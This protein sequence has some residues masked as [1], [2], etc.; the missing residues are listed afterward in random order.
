[1]A[2]AEMIPIG[3]RARP[4][5]LALLLAMAALS[6][7]TFACVTPFVAFAVLVVAT[8][9]RRGAILAMLGVW[10]I[11]QALGYLAL[12]YPVN[13][14]GLAWGVAIGI[15]AA[16]A[17]LAAGAILARPSWP[18]LGGAFLAAVA[19]YEGVLFLV[20]LALGGSAN[21]A[22]RIIALVTLSDAA[23]LI[24]VAALGLLLSR[25]AAILAPARRPV[26]T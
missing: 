17:T 19:S 1:M 13:G 6:S 20:S 22:P 18:R 7:V 12:G 21:F 11:N 15:A 16:V 14:I 4:V 24:G 3:G 9:P 25:L 10:L 23:W 8:L 2:R 5:W 26:T